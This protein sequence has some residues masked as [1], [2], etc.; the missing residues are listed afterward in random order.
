MDG[1][2]DEPTWLAYFL[3]SSD[4][5]SAGMVRPAA[6]RY[7]PSSSGARAF[8]IDLDGTLYSSGRLLPG[9]RRFYRW[10]LQSRTPHVFLSNTGSKGPEG[11]QAKLGALP[12]KLHDSPVPLARILT[13]ADAQADYMASALPEGRW[14]RAAPAPAPPA[15]PARSRTAC[16]ARP[17]PP[18]GSR[19][20]VVS[21]GGSFWRTLL[22]RR[23]AA[24]VASWDV[25]TALSDEQAMQ[26]ALEA[27]R[28][29]GPAGAALPK[30]VVAFFLDGDVLQGDG[31]AAEA[32]R[33]DGWNYGL[34][35]HCA[36]LLGH[37]AHLIYTAD[38]PFNP[39]SAEAHA[40]AVFPL[41]GPGARRAAHARAAT[42]ARRQNAPAE[43]GP[44]LPPLFRR[45]VRVDAAPGDPARLAGPR[46]LLRQ[47]C[48][49]GVRTAARQ[50]RRPVRSR[51]PGRAP[52]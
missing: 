46:L 5:A 31:R 50:G 16:A 23:D 38:D 37:G 10:L 27:S 9:A 33:A 28:T 51:C 44:A 36:F 11:T 26:W 48:A 15:R 29:R 25:R 12:Y 17:L 18:P 7:D 6:L 24:R 49:K 19:V 22:E 21:G 41:P 39:H 34:I 20:L 3:A 14:A 43:H 40:D 52:G 4:E 32:A 47:R 42:P 2:I 8:L 1:G 30:V 45:H 35:K 13:A